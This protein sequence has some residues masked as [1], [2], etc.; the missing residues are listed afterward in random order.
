VGIGIPK[1]DVIGGMPCA[2][3][4]VLQSSNARQQ[5]SAYL[6]IAATLM[7]VGILL[8]FGRASRTEAQKEVFRKK[9]SAILANHYWKLIDLPSIIVEALLHAAP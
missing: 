8:D 4:S 1:L 6:H 3:R 7:S 2:R 5:R 9:F